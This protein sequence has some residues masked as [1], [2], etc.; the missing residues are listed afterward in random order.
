MIETKSPP[1]PRGDYYFWWPHTQYAVDGD[2]PW[3][4]LPGSCGMPHLDYYNA[5]DDC[6]SSNIT[7]I[8]PNLQGQLI[9]QDPS[10]NTSRDI[11]TDQSMATPCNSGLVIALFLE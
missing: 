7:Q 8:K 9:R 11:R 10:D 6:L 1:P 5:V 4:R 3:F 2:M